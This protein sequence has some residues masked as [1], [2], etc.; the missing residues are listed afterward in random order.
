[1]KD[2]TQI[3]NRISKVSDTKIC[4]LMMPLTLSDAGV[5]YVSEAVP[6]QALLFTLNTDAQGFCVLLETRADC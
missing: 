5:L 4:I 2:L 6:P 3:L 1:M